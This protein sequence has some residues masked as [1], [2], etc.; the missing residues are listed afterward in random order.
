MNDRR[1]QFA[2]LKW[3]VCRSGQRG[4]DTD[5]PARRAEGPCAMPRLA[6]QFA[7]EVLGTGPS[8]R[9]V[10]YRPIVGKGSELRQARSRDGTAWGQLA[11]CERGS[12]PSCSGLMDRPLTNTS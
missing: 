10:D 7:A 12:E 2:R 6:S 5:T 3:T 9:Q 1:S 8:T 11:A 4:T